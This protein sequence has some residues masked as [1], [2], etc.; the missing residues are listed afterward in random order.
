M[1]KI[2]IILSLILV[3]CKKID[4]PIITPVNKDIF[5]TSRS[6]VTNGQEIN[7]VLKNAGIY[8][9]TMIDSAQNQVITRE[10]FIGK[11]GENK[12]KI[13]TRSIDIKYLYLILEDANKVQINKTSIIIN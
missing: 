12:L 2:F 7:F 11:I 5:S 9:L 4:T 8:T 10:R 1:K 13:Y 3:A 6:S